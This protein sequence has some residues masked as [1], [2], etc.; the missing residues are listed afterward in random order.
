MQTPSSALI[1]NCSRFSFRPGPEVALTK[2]NVR[3]IMTS[4]EDDRK[5]ASGG[6][7]QLIKLALQQ[8]GRVRRFLLVPSSTLTS[9]SEDGTESR[10]LLFLVLSIFRPLLPCSTLLVALTHPTNNA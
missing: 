9:E 7:T 3:E 5:S 2:S 8:A 10:H 4:G 6:S 1:R